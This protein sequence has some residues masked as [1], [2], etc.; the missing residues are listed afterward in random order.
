MLKSFKKTAFS[1]ALLT[2]GTF[3]L[4]SCEQASELMKANISV[5]S[6][7]SA[8][9]ILRDYEYGADKK[10]ESAIRVS[11]AQNEFEGAQLILN[12]DKD[13]SYTVE[14]SDLTNGENVI[15]AED[16]EI[17]QQHYVET[18]FSTKDYYYK[19]MDIS[20][21]WFPDALLPFETAVEYR[22]NKLVKGRNQ[23]VWF[24]FETQED[25]PAGTYTGSIEVKAGASTINV[26]VSLEVWDFVISEETHC[27]TLFNQYRDS[28][29]SVFG[30]GSEEM[31]EKYYEFLLDYRINE[32]KLPAKSDDIQ[33]YVEIVKKYHNDSRVNTWALPTYNHQESKAGVGSSTP[34]GVDWRHERMMELMAAI[35][36]ESVKDGVNY[37]EKAVHYPIEA[38]EFTGSW[39]PASKLESAKETF[40]SFRSYT[41]KLA[42]Q[43]DEIYGTAYL[44]SVEGLRDSVKW[45]PEISVSQYNQNSMEIMQYANI[46]C[47]V[48]NEATVDAE[49]IQA[50]LF[51][52]E[53]LEYGEVQENKEMWTY[54]C[55]FPLWPNPTVHIDD[56]L[57][58]SR[59]AFWMCYDYGFSGYLYWTTVG[60]AQGRTEN[61]SVFSAWEN[62]SYNGTNGDANFVY[63]GSYYG[64]DGPVPT[65]RLESLR[66]GLEEYE[67]F[68]LLDNLYSEMK[69]YYGVD[70]LSYRNVCNDIYSSLYNTEGRFSNSTTGDKVMEARE[71]VAQAIVNVNAK[72]CLIV[73][74]EWK[75]GND[76][77][78]SVLLSNDV[79]VTE[80]ANLISTENAGQGKRYTFKFD[81]SGDERITLNLNYTVDG[82]NKTYSKLIK[83]ATYVLADMN[84][85][86]DLTKV[87]VS[88][89]STKSV[90]KLEGNDQVLL[91]IA[92]INANTQVWFNFIMNKMGAFDGERLQ[93]SIY[94][95]S[96]RTVSVNMVYKLTNSDS[97]PI[98]L[99][100]AQGWNVFDVDLS[101]YG[102]S[103]VAAI[104]FMLE[105]VDEGYKFYIG[106]VK[107]YEK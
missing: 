86:S 58:G 84:A 81:L 59:L 106:K 85:Q 77:Y 9:K 100:L 44:D 66:D 107:Y 61:K 104:A 13:V 30:D 83:K 69:E 98:A 76:H 67:Y 46:W 72:E 32:Q 35:V 97:A 14:I 55:N 34:E 73:E 88:L 17:Y 22:E 40:I 45:L 16:V 56:E 57:F 29:T 20:A 74:K 82:V 64:I 47:P 65:I 92:K 96:G 68:Y 38:D 41:L 53:G 93:I 7:N 90:A 19:V 51:M 25:T 26:P 6:A 78:V 48:I 80:N 95:D 8:E 11:L 49:K 62:A 42:E 63:P 10:G 70:S 50:D 23:G 15:P 89:G 2:A 87:N 12:T 3:V 99:E 18:T 75:E 94:N 31:Y 79:T 21:G 1:L 27:R 71:K 105:N 28:F 91:E 54:S 52:D 5:W 102:V 37:L 43:F 60:G 103:Q 4:G 36:V 33:S 24:T 101:A 39:Q